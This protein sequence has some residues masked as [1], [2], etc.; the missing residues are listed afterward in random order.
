VAALPAP[1]GM[2]LNADSM[3]LRKAVLN[4]IIRQA[5]P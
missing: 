4:T 1:P 3:N 2:L 5:E